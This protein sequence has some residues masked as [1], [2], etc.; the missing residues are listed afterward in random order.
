MIGVNRGY[1]N[2]TDIKQNETTKGIRGQL[3]ISQLVAQTK[4]DFYRAKFVI[5][6]ENGLL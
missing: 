2:K 4:V 1:V 3:D 6:N 5:F